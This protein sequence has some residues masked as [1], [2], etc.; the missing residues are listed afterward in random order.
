MALLLEVSEIDTRKSD[1]FEVA[2]CSHFFF[3]L[4]NRNLKLPPYYG[5]R[6]AVFKRHIR[7]HTFGDILLTHSEILRTKRNAV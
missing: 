5:V 7:T 1:R 2:N 6:L 3:I 4:T